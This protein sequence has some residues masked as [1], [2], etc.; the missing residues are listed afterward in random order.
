MIPD[1]ARLRA[2]ALS[3]GLPAV[4]DGT[5]WGHPCVRAHGR[6]WVWWSPLVDAAV[7]RCDRSEREMLLEVDPETF[8]LHPHYRNHDLVLVRAGRID[9]AWATPRLIRDWRAAAP[10]RW[11]KAWDAGGAA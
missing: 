6:M 8:V 11:L 3:L 9:P 10:K 5:A 7:F 2:L 4:M 1:Y